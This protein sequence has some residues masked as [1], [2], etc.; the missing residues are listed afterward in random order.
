M[1]RKETGAF[2][3]KPKVQ[4]ASDYAVEWK[5]ELSSLFPKNMAIAEAQVVVRQTARRWVEDLKRKLEEKFQ[6]EVQ[7]RSEKTGGQTDEPR[8]RPDTDPQDQRGAQG[9][10]SVG[11]DAGTK[12]QDPQGAQE[13]WRGEGDADTE[14]Q[15]PP[16]KHERSAG[17]AAGTDTQDTDGGA[18][19]DRRTEEP[20]LAISAQPAPFNPGNFLVMCEPMRDVIEQLARF[21]ELKSAVAALD[22]AI[23]LRN[24]EAAIDA[25]T[26]KWAR[27]GPKTA[28]R[29]SESSMAVTAVPLTVP[30]L[31]AVLLEQK[32]VESKWSLRTDV[33]PA[34]LKEAAGPF[35]AAVARATEALVME[36]KECRRN[37]LKRTSKSASAELRLGVMSAGPGIAN[38]WEIARS[39]CDGGEEASLEP[40]GAGALADVCDVME[41][42]GQVKMSILLPMLGMGGAKNSE[43]LHVIL[44]H[45]PVLTVATPTETY[46]VNATD[47]L[48]GNLSGITVDPDAA[49]G[50]GGGDHVL[51]VLPPVKVPSKKGCTKHRVVADFPDIGE[52]IEAI[53]GSRGA[54]ETVKDRRPGRA[55]APLKIV[56]LS[57]DKIRLALAEEWDIHT[58]RT[59]LHRM[60]AQPRKNSTQRHSGLVDA[61]PSSHRKTDTVW[62]PRQHQ[63]NAQVVYASEWLRDMYEDGEVCLQLNVDDYKCVPLLIDASKDRPRGYVMRGD[64]PKHLDHDFV[65]QRKLLIRTSGYVASTFSPKHA[66]IRGDQPGSQPQ[67]AAE[68]GPIAKSSNLKAA[69][70]SRHRPPPPT[71]RMWAVIRDFDE[72][73]DA[74]A[75]A[76]DV[77][78]IAR[79]LVEAPTALLI[80]SDNGHGYNPNS[81][82]G[83]FFAARIMKELPSLKALLLRSHAP[84]ASKFNNKIERE[85]NRFG[86]S[87]A[88]H[89][90]AASLAPQLVGARGEERNEVLARVR[91]EGK[92]QAASLFRQITVGSGN[93][94]VSLAEEE[95]ATWKDMPDVHA[96]CMK[97]QSH[98]AA[99][100]HPMWK[101]WLVLREYFGQESPGCADFR[102]PLQRRLPPIPI[103]EPEDEKW[104]EGKEKEM[105]GQRNREAPPNE[106]PQKCAR[107]DG[108]IVAY[109]VADAIVEFGEGEREDAGTKKTPPAP[110]AILGQNCRFQE[111]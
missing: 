31:R 58:S 36:A 73:S 37:R 110:A 26:K 33:P 52:K 35:L 46:M 101:E 39:A 34:A 9:R 28:R 50:S 45:L 14:T 27:F 55:D 83:K 87:L 64:D 20:G 17:G 88:G 76:N 8:R 82:C 96:F 16:G 21:K 56:S 12:P 84:Y 86:L 72:K 18:D 51:E 90:L 75:H 93:V 80:V 109:E 40:L 106:P 79:S 6:S 63:A 15:D 104:F 13:Q 5:A 3:G 81:D 4:S 41:A 98:K 105:E 10:E 78:R 32:Q 103:P 2:E 65:L 7:W 23:G 97:T 48:W 71:Q 1:A 77:I 44:A 111:N 67:A 22:G 38:S 108:A 89:R 43:V 102:G 69:E 94:V 11:G 95:E 30:R 29:T 25:T 91:R 74:C 107:T 57:L 62:H 19:D 68:L 54:C 60:L 99:F 42:F 59:T 92:R 53:L 70:A 49:R 61:R 47:N 100:E 85:W 66:E 24:Q